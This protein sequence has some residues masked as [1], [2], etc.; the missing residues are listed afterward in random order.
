MKYLNIIIIFLSFSTEIKSRPQDYEGQFE[1]DEGQRQLEQGLFEDVFNDH[2]RQ[3]PNDVYEEYFNDPSKR[4]VR[5]EEGRTFHCKIEY[6]H[7]PMLKT[8]VS[9][10]PKN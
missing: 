1:S 5:D 7:N 8:I 2:P 3:I 10:L 9:H 6:K 4:L